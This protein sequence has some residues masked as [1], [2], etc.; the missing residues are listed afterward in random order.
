[1]NVYSKNDFLFRSRNA[2]R[3]HPAVIACVI[4]TVFVVVGTAS[5]SVKA[6]TFDE[7]AHLLGGYMALTAR[8]YHVNPENGLFPQ[9]WAA[10][11]LALSPNVKP[12]DLHSQTWSAGLTWNMASNFLYSTPGNDSD[13]ILL[14]AR[15]MMMLLAAA[16]GFLVFAISKRIWGVEGGFFSLLLFVLSSTV[17]A[18]ARLVTSDV[19]AAFFFLLS[20][21][22]FQL[23]AERLTVRR[24]ALFCSGISALFLSKMSAPIIF[25]MLLAIFALRIFRR[26][27]LKIQIG[28]ANFA[29]RRQS[30]QAFTLFCAILLAGAAVFASIW[31]AS[32][33]RF[34]MLPDNV[35]RTA[36]NRKW[37]LMKK[38][39]SFPVRTILLAK[40]YKILPEHYLYG[41]AHVIH[42]SKS[43]HA[44][45]NGKRS[46]T[47]WWYFFPATF[48]MKT[49][50]E[51]L[52][53]ILLGL[54]TLF[55]IPLSAGGEE[56]RGNGKRKFSI[57]NV[58]RAVPNGLARLR[59]KAILRR[60]A[61]AFVL[62]TTYA[63]FSLATNMNIGHRHL[64]PIYPPL[65]IIGGGAAYALVHWNRRVQRRQAA[66]GIRATERQGE[67]NECV[68]SRA[69]DSFCPLG[70]SDLS[71]SKP[72]GVQTAL[73]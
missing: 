15:F 13:S 61:F 54:V 56:K 19:A 44:F 64:L 57:M 55:F 67:E 3:K 72:S 69:S 51:L 26:K 10:L 46:M 33:F 62:I 40:K 38:N 47:G 32:A 28:S 53:F 68:A 31:G 41:M 35:V 17:M 70:A 1:M 37:E 12:P 65:I 73:S 60:F 29:L 71:N 49:P 2:L 6:P 27:P 9:T 11:P 43:R 66:N 48:A 7:T 45:L 30:S 16:C 23:L 20:V 34:S 25:P 5:V 50:P 36:Q 59:R 42:E 58:Q 52:L 4:L 24:M 8:D 39:A 63:G 21:W 14:K 22:S 18:N